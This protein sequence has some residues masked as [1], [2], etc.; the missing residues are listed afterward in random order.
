MVEVSGLPYGLMG[1]MLQDGGN[2]YRGMIYGMTNRA[3]RNDPRPI[4]KIW[5]DFGIAESRMLGY[6]VPYC[7]VKTDRD[8][9]KATVYQRQGK[10]LVSVASWADNIIN[11][12]LTIDWEALGIDSESAE[13]YAPAIDGFQPEKTWK[14]DDT[15]AI[16]KGK[17]YLIII[18]KNK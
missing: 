10:A 5:D 9:V 3:P 13:L 6:W 14:P 17:G 8:D 4:W 18:R 15:I 16:S 2:L 11:A 1:E 7:P 12:K